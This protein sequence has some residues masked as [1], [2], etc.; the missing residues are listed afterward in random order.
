MIKFNFTLRQTQDIGFRAVLH[1]HTT[2]FDI[3]VSRKE[4]QTLN[5]QIA[6]LL[7]M[8]EPTVPKPDSFE[9]IVQPPKPR[10][11]KTNA[12]Q[13]NHCKDVIISRHCHDFVTCSCGKVSVDG[14]VNYLRR[15]GDPNDWT[16]LSEYVG[17]VPEGDD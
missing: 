16:E 1:N 8:E 11:I 5:D 7:S 12:V 6:Y 4:L 10:V 2:L 15:A 9:M 14:G 13:C 17:D 3:T